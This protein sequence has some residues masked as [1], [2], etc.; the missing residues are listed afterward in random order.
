[1]KSLDL[2]SEEYDVLNEFRDRAFEKIYTLEKPLKQLSTEVSKVSMAIDQV[3]EYS[4]SYNLKLVGVPE[5]EPRENAFQ[6]LQ[7][8]SVIYIA[9]GVHVKPYDID[10]THRMT[11]CH[12]AKRRPKPII[13]KFT[14]RLIRK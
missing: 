13:C 11:P 5:L 7:L 9:I 12:A 4:Y 6:T 8:C 1:M 10:I 14:Q 2:L 3:Q